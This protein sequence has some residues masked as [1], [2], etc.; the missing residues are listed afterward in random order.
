MKKPKSAFNFEELFPLASQIARMP[1]LTPYSARDGTTLF[2]RY[3]PAPCDRHLILLHGSAAHGAVL[4]A[5]AVYLTERGIVNVHV[6]DLRGHGVS[7]ARRGDIDYEGQLEDDLADL[8]G[9]VQQTF[10]GVS[11]IFVGGHSSG[12]GLAL[13]FGAG[14]HRELADG[15]L[16]LAPYLGHDAPVVKRN[17][18][19]WARPNIP[20]IVL[21]S[22]LE[23]FGVRRY[24]GTKVLRFNLPAQFQTGFETLEYSFR[25]MKG[26]HPTGFR[27]SL[28]RCKVPLLV[29]VGAPDESIQASKFREAFRCLNGRAEVHILSHE[30]HLGIIMSERCMSKAADWIAEQA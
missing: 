12:G 21:L 1:A 16:L 6:P 3:Y 26:M 7:P 17:A 5:F 9:H 14:R 18:G 2:V 25:L 29:L 20:L 24:S 4:H 22:A 23:I 27:N 11:G 15:L 19:G 10:G 8:I 13:R 30:S 28:R